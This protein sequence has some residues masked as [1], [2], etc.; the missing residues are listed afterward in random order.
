M[1]KLAT[2]NLLVAAA[3][4]FLGSMVLETYGGD[5]TLLLLSCASVIPI[6]CAV[7]LLAVRGHLQSARR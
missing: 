3:A 5:V 2:P 7:G 4:P 1:G 6:A